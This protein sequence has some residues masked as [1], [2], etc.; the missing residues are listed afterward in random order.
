MLLCYRCFK[1]IRNAAA[2]AGRMP[3][4]YQVAAY[5]NAVLSVAG[6]GRNGQDLRLPTI[7]TNQPVR[8]SLMHVQALCALLLNIVVTLDTELATTKAAEDA[9]LDRWRNS[10]PFTEVSAVPKRRKSRMI[11]LNNRVGLP[12]LD[13]NEALYELLRNARLV[14]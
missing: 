8:L 9:L 2:H 13:D 14:I 12:K 10:I 6:L 11:V 4:A 1:E 7:A 5:T 3:D